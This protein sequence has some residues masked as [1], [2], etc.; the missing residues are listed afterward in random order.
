M[1]TQTGA[2]LHQDHMETI[3]SLQALEEFIGRHR[4]T[5]PMDAAL[6]TRLSKL[7]TTMRNEVERHF[8]F[9]ESHLFPAFM[10]RGEVGIVTMLTQEHRSI[11]PLALEVADAADGA[12]QD[13]FTDG[14]WADFRD[15]A[16]E[17]VEREIFHIQKEE[18]GL[19]SAISVLLDA[20]TDAALATI[21]REVMG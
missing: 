18:M 8:G 5:P 15:S 11:L 13:G 10:R 1:Q 7:A 12:A 9:E 4:K 21:Y 2:L 19:L 20:D 6:A 3:A 17:L 16:T 14:A